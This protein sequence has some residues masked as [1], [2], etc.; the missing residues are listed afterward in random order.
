M[1]YSSHEHVD[2]IADAEVETS[3]AERINSNED[4]YDD[5]GDDSESG[6]STYSS[7]YNSDINDQ[8]RLMSDFD[9][10]VP[11]DFDAIP[12]VAATVLQDAE[13]AVPA[14]VVQDGM[15]YS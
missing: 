11:C 9:S 15:S 2:L 10:Q 4:G 3:V 6:S 14:M 1:H 13:E 8:Q 7:S 5:D 12:I